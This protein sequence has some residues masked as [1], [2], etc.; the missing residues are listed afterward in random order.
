MIL[1]FFGYHNLFGINE[2]KMI[3]LKSELAKINAHS[4]LNI[5]K[6]LHQK[7]M[8]IVV[9]SHSDLFDDYA[10]MIIDLKVPTF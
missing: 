10:E 1:L 6:K 2:E 4:V 9:V 7:G 8:M 3:S 5:F